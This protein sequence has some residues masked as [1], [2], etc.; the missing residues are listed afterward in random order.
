MIEFLIISIISFITW[1]FFVRIGNT[2]LVLI[3]VVILFLFI[4]S[5]LWGVWIWS[6][7]K[8]HIKDHGSKLSRWIIVIG[9]ILLLINQWIVRYHVIAITVL[10]NIIFYFSSY[11]WNY[12]EGKTVFLRWIIMTFLVGVFYTFQTWQYNSIAHIITI[13][14]IILLLLSYSILWL[15]R[16][17]SLEDNIYITHQKEFSIYIVIWIILY[18]IFQPNYNAILVSQLA[19]I[20]FTIGLRQTYL[21]RK[22]EIK[23]EKK[24]WLSGRSLLA[25]QKVL[26]WYDNQNQ[27]LDLHIFNFLINKGYM[28]SSYG[29]IILQYSQ[30]IWIIILIALSIRS[31]FQNNGYTLI[32]YWLGIFCF[33]ITL[34]WIQSQEKFIQYYKTIAIGLITGSYYITLFDTTHSSSTFTRWSLLRLCINMIIA[35]FYQDIFPQSKNLFT[36]N[37]IVFWL[38]MIIIGSIITTLSLVWLAL[39]WQILFA[40]WCIIIGIVSYFSYHIWKTVN[41]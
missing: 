40:I 8:N 41:K 37:D 17:L 32:R 6:F 22:K 28:P 2:R 38:I 36:K 3:P 15:F 5:W 7:T 20:T 9:I 18:R 34:F 23:H 25:W 24:T 11:Q 29:M 21:T 13:G 10:L 26:E 33:I 30:I 14:G 31:L 4:M 39:P 1:Y 27:S 35:L 16:K 19:F 12:K